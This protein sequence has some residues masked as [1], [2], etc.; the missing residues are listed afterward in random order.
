MGG[1]ASQVTQSVSIAVGKRA[2]IDL[3]GD[4]VAPPQKVIHLQYS[5]VIYGL[6]YFTREKLRL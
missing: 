5:S 2:G 4:A 1:D 3:V 6:K